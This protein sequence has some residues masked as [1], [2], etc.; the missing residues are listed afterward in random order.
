MTI[1][2]VNNFS[3]HFIICGLKNTGKYSTRFSYYHG[4]GNDLIKRVYSA[5]KSQVNVSLDGSSSLTDNYHISEDISGAAQKLWSTLESLTYIIQCEVMDI[6][7][8]VTRQSV[9]RWVEM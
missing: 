4:F 5:T 3:A 6:N 1:K 8:Y 2:I 7:L 9:T